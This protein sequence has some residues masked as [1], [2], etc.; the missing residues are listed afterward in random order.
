MKTGRNLIHICLLSALLL[1]AF[2][3]GAEP[4]TKIVAP[5]SN[6]HWSNSVF[7]V[8]GTAKDNVAISNVFY[9]LNGAAWTPATGGSNWT[10]KVPL[11]PGANTIQA[12]AVDTSGNASKT[13][14]VKLDY[15][16]N[17]T[18]MVGTN[19]EGRISPA[20]GGATLQ[21]S[22]IYY[23]K[24]KQDKG[25]AFV[26]W[27]DGLGNIL[28]YGATLKFIMASNLTFIANFADIARPTL[29]ITTPKTG[30]K[31][32]NSVFTVI[33]TAKDN[34]AISNVFY[35][36]NGAAWTPATGGSNWTTKVP[37]TP[38]ANTIQAYAVDTSGNASKTDSVKLDYIQSATLTVQIVG[39][40]TLTPD[41]NGQLL[42]ISNGYTMK[43]T[44]GT[45]FAF[46]YWSGGVTMTTNPVLTFTMITGLS[47]IAN[48]KDVTRPITAITFP[49][50]NQKWSN[51]V[52]TVTGNASDNV[53]VADVSFQM[54]N[55]G[56][57]EAQS[58]NG[59]TN[60]T[61]ANLSAIPG[62][63]I[64]Q[65]YAVDAANNVS[66]T[67]KVQFLN[68]SSAGVSGGP[69]GV[70]NNLEDWWPLAGDAN[71]H[72]G[73]NNATTY[74]SPSYADGTCEAASGA[75]ALDGSQY[76]SAPDSALPLGNASR[77]VSFWVDFQSLP[78]SGN[79]YGLFAYG[80]AGGDNEFAF[81]L[82]NSGGN[83]YVQYTGGS[84][85]FDT[86][87][88]NVTSN[89]WYCF[90][91]TYDGNN[92]TVYLDGI[93]L[94]SQT[95]TGWNTT[96]GGG[97]YI[98]SSLVGGNPSPATI[99]DFRIYN[100]SLTGDQVQAGF[101]A[102][103][104]PLEAPDLLYLKML[105]DINAVPQ[106]SYTD[107]PAPLADASA[108]GNIHVI[109]H[110]NAGA[111]DN[112][113]LSNIGGVAN[114]ALHWHGV[115]GSYAD[116]GDSN[117]FAFTTN[118]FSVGF[119]VQPLVPDSIFFS[120]GIANTNGWAVSEDSGNNLFMNFSTNGV[121]TSVG[122]GNVPVHNDAWHQI[123][124]SVR[125]GTNVSIY[126]DGLPAITGSV[127]VP[128]PS[129]TNTLLI[130]EKNLGGYY[131]S[132]LDGNLWMTQIWSR[133]LSAPDAAL[134]YLHQLSGSPWP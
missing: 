82:V 51:S 21:I 127:T 95:E 110:S 103:A 105:D 111:G 65:A 126:R 37:L 79:A 121:T 30:E 50:L 28:T 132:F 33:G 67:N 42:M 109:Y 22:N 91:F 120:C 75:I 69:T 84:D 9:S 98:G 7:T 129:G 89:Q 106:Y 20:Y 19:G 43:A 90:T 3:S 128:A 71:D 14:S 49:T 77:T 8:I 62:T 113:W 130:G 59:F 2:H 46:S 119:W 101:I 27:T 45:G 35:S 70:T 5:K 99:A 32:S 39:S 97:V 24:A 40:G 15:I 52:I 54:N 25:F 100:A 23:I 88:V 80:N 29:T 122:G 53:S 96:S 1:R 66:L 10:T 61:A 31:W 115:D 12:Y 93:V 36:L 47:I 118:D 114:S 83:C 108:V 78:A 16:L 57:M 92:A 6:Q 4:V 134:L 13:D 11:T 48:F 104:C 64:V 123:L 17:T 86:G 102:A 81:N 58:D 112:V 73:T 68:L 41:Y 60:W 55:G 116:T 117:H 94:N 74:G 26:D 44:A 85:G 133:N 87:P 124:I 72:W 107:W 18:L 38:G 125:G 76:L 56:W 34:V 63:N 131:G